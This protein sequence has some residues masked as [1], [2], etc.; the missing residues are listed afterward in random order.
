MDFLY[1][2][3]GFVL[4]LGIVVTV[5]ELG[6]Y[7]AARSVGVHVLRFSVGFGKAL[8]G[9]E[10]KHGTHFTLS[11]IP[12]GGYVKLLGEDE[13]ES[14]I[15]LD[16]MR[17]GSRRSF[18]DLSGWQKI[19]IAVAGPG[20]NFALSILVFAII[21]FSGSYEPAPAFRVDTLDQPLYEQIGEG[22][23]EISKV[24]DV[25]TKT[26][27]G[28]Q[29]ALAD[30]LGD[31]GVI[32]FILR[33][34]E[35]ELLHSVDVPILNWHR[36]ESEPDLLA[37]L[38]IR[39]GVFPLLGKI[40]VGSPA[41]RAGLVEGDLVTRLN[42][43][44]VKYWGD[45]VKLIEAFPGASV[46]IEILRNG[47]PVS[48][49]AGI[50]SKFVTNE[51]TVGYLGVGPKVEFV[52]NDLGSAIA[53]GFVKAWDM[54]MMT[55]SFFKK[56]IFGEL[57]AG[58]LMGPIGIAKVAGEVVQTG[59]IQFL[60]VLALMSLSLGIINLMPIPMLDGGMVLL[61]L[62]EL[63]MGKPI[64]ENLQVMGFQFG[65]LLIGGLFVFVTYN[66][67]LRIF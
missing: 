9:F 16:D 24:D 57:S 39:P 66:D 58:T 11:I 44:P 5:H 56:M 19:F 15:P 37:S 67:L 43:T 31:S 25:E 1:Y 40:V 13:S 51:L 26:W 2:P 45:L 12:L 33:D 27:S 42:G 14:V 48:I 60:T 28:I 41:F 4:L 23:Y 38:G 50:G 65:V 17:E 63:I 20:A 30:R 29:L 21:S 35:R 49:M 32:R 6:H 7:L 52:E 10:D 22:L 47:R 8:F 34:V 53:E 64:P 62:I 46:E 61:N 3:L 36:D 18:L 59:I 54:T 55:L